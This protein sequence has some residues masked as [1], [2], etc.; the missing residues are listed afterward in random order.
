VKELDALVI[1]RIFGQFT[2]RKL[3]G[4]TLRFQ[5]TWCLREEYGSYVFGEFNSLKQKKL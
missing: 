4:K 5:A 3:R 2:N 1:L